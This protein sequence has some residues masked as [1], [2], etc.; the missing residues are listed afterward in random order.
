MLWYFYSFNL[1]VADI[2][3]AVIIILF[4]EQLNSCKERREG[5]PDLVVDQDQ[6]CLQF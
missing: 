3:I 2:V 6:P 5:K 4:G 1:F